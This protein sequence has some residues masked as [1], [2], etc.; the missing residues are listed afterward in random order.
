MQVILNYKNERQIYDKV[1]GIYRITQKGYII[2]I[3]K[4]YKLKKSFNVKQ[5]PKLKKLGI[6]FL[7]K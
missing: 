4:I 2:M 6:I 3:Q 1:I 7:I 5:I